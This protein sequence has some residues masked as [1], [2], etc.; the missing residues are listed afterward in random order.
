MNPVGTVEFA[1]SRSRLSSFI[2]AADIFG[3]ITTNTSYEVCYG[4]DANAGKFDHINKD[5]GCQTFRAPSPKCG[6][7]ETVTADWGFL[8]EFNADD[9]ENYDARMATLALV[10]AWK[11][12]TIADFITK[13][14]SLPTQRMLDLL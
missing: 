13:L 4:G 7:G 1:R 8:K 2:S 6:K 14:M 3:R 5:T 10:G 11:N 12:K 9:L